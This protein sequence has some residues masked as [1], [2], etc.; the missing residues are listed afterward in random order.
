MTDGILKEDKVHVGAPEEVIVLVQ[1]APQ[2]VHQD[3]GVVQWLKWM[4]Q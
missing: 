3:T 4:Q 2:L 1:E